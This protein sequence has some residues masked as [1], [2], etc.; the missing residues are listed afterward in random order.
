MSD[1]LSIFIRQCVH[2]GGI[3]F[4]I[5]TQVD[6]FLSEANMRILIKSIKEASEGKVITKTFEDLQEMEKCR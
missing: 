6:P 2:Q 4:E 3:P 5:T 1:A